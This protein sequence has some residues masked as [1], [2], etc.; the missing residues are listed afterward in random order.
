MKASEPD[1]ETIISVFH[2][3]GMP[4]AEREFVSDDGGCCA[5][6]AFALEAGYRSMETDLDPREWLVETYGLDDQFVEG[7]VQ[8]NDGEPA[9]EVRNLAW[10]GYTPDDH[11][12][13]L[14]G[15]SVGMAVRRHFL[16]D[17]S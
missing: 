15:R 1:A 13:Y 8:G 17:E 5:L 14:R 16:G 7:V 12:R 4:W 6:T 3:L 10:A 11:A 9:R 2:R